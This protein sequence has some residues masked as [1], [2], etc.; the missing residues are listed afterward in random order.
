[1]ICT[2]SQHEGNPL[3]HAA[4]SPVRGARI[5]WPT[6][7]VRTSIKDIILTL[8][9]LSVLTKSCRAFQH[10]FPE[11]SLILHTVRIGLSLQSKTTD[12]YAPS[13]EMICHGLLTPASGSS[14]T[15]SPASFAP[16][17]RPLIEML[18]K[19][20]PSRLTSV[21]CTISNRQHGDDLDECN[22]RV[23]R[24]VEDRHFQ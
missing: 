18:Y 23:V 9:V 3:Q 21:N 10:D 22:K 2:R 20:T 16:I 8:R 5:L 13:L 11:A 24:S 14:R 15:S 12:W 7:H 17:G 4:R 6:L 1:M 19:L